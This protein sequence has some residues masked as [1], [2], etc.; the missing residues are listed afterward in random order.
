MTEKKIAVINILDRGNGNRGMLEHILARHPGLRIDE[1]LA[2]QIVGSE[3]EKAEIYRKVTNGLGI[4][5]SHCSGH[6]E[7]GMKGS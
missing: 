3:L 4:P 5:K 2:K 7:G 1:D 6:E